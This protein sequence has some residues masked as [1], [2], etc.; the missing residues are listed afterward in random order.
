MSDAYIAHLVRAVDRQSKDPGSNPGTVKCVSLF[1]ERF[2]ILLNMIHIFKIS[3]IFCIMF[4]SEVK[5]RKKILK[6]LSRPATHTNAC[7][8]YRLGV[9][10]IYYKILKE[11]PELGRG[12]EALLF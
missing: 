1:T 8:T 5:F 2:Q 11:E 9:L 10:K 3:R 12:N 7:I 4:D 6:I